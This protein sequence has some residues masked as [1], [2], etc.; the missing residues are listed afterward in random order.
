MQSTPFLQDFHATTGQEQ[1][2]IPCVGP[3]IELNLLAGWQDRFQDAVIRHYDLATGN[4][5]KTSRS[6]PNATLCL[7]R[8]R[9]FLEGSALKK[10]SRK[11]R[12]SISTLRNGPTGRP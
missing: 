10:P 1:Y 11:L 4:I 12:S 7:E 6:L 2:K 8:R 9:R 3:D 5:Y